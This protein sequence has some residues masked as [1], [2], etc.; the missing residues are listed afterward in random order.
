MNRPH[1]LACRLRAL[2]LVAA[3][4]VMVATAARAAEVPLWQGTVSLPETTEAARGAGYAEALK[5]VAVKVSGRREAASNP[6]IASADPARLVQRYSTGANRE[7]TVGFDPRATS[8]LLQQAGLPFWAAERPVTLVDA[9]V[10][11]RIEAERAARYRGLPIEW[12]GAAPS[13]AQAQLRGTPAGTGYDWT[14]SHAGQ[15]VQ[16]R[17]TLADGIHLAADTLA[18]RYAPPSTRGANA[19]PLRVSGMDG[20]AAYAGVLAYLNSLSIVR[21]VAVEALEGEVLQLR[22][23]QRGDLELLARLAAL[24][25]RLVP[26]AAGAAEGGGADFRYQP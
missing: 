23:V 14:F 4:L 1:R 20:Y 2:G 21:E 18:A 17:G 11:D 9:P 5:A 15:T 13:S 6:A 10:T 16:G 19:Y 24:D 7:L 12:S 8:A 25:G 22:V 3:G 26:V